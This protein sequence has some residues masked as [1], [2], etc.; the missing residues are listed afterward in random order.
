MYLAALE[1][2]DFVVK[3]HLFGYHQVVP[4]AN[5]ANLAVE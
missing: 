1:T 2:C 4:V 5:L 3:L